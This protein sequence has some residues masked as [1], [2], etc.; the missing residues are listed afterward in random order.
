VRSAESDP[1]LITIWNEQRG[2]HETFNAS[3]YGYGYGNYETI[4]SK[5]TDPL[6]GR[7]TEPSYIESIAFYFRRRQ[8][9]F[10]CEKLSEKR[11]S[12]TVIGDF[13]YLP[14]DLAQWLRL[15]PLDPPDGFV[16]DL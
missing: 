8:F 5:E 16:K 1:P 14:S 3:I 10:V 13:F 2:V 7:P 4:Y 12:F 11:T 6:S 15:P 9:V